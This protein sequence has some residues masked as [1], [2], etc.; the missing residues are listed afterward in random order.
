VAAAD[1]F[2]IDGGTT[3]IFKFRRA[4]KANRQALEELACP[5]ACNG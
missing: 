2:A 4:A 5:S 3:A 1:C